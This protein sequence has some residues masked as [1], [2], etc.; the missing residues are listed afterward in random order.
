MK[1]K[2]R[3]LL[4]VCIHFNYR[5]VVLGAW[6]CGAFGHDAKEVAKMFYSILVEEEYR[7]HFDQ[8]V[9]AIPTFSSSR[10]NYE[11]FEEVFHQTQL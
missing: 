2:I 6:G 7:N 3:D 11:A 5:N 9:F 10:K 4:N 8:V 1:I